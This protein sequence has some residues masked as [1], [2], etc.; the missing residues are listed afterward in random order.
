M[1][2]DTCPDV[3]LASSGIIH[4]LEIGIHMA[5]GQ[6][7]VPP[8]NIP[9]PTEIPE[10]PTKMGGAPTPKWDP[11][12]VDPRPYQRNLHHGSHRK[13]PSGAAII[14]PTFDAPKY[15]VDGRNLLRTSWNG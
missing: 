10:I 2:L 4:Q 15:A 1:L 14:C 8:V 13:S 9:I 6:N 7:P 11:I 3:E 5:M 12:G